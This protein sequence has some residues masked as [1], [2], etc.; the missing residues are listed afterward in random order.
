MT[1]TVPMAILRAGFGLV[2]SILTLPPLTD[3]DEALSADRAEH[4]SDL[5]MSIDQLEE[6]ALSQVAA[7]QLPGKHGVDAE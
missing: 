2:P 7:D 1:S 3:G 4:E 5:G 6:L